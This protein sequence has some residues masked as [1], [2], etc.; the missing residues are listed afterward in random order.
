MT[1]YFVERFIE[2][3]T[4]SNNKGDIILA[5]NVGFFKC[6]E[7]LYEI[8]IIIYWDGVDPNLPV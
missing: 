7:I 2:R 4:Y 5:M 1:I 6:F 8:L 3:F